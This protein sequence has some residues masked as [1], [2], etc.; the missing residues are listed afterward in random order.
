MARTW[1][2]VIIS[3]SLTISLVLFS[4]LLSVPLAH[5]CP[6]PRH[7]RSR[8]AAAALSEIGWQEGVNPLHYAQ[9]FLRSSV[10][11]IEK[12]PGR[13]VTFIPIPRLTASCG[14]AATS[15]SNCS[16]SRIHSPDLCVG[17]NL[18]DQREKSLSRSES[19]SGPKKRN[20]NRC[21]ENR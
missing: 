19:G 6:P 3:L 7:S 2:V 5:R 20:E 13:F 18:P 4:H 10:H 16:L 15:S 12:F 11:L 1:L 21:C 14:Y 9:S 17:E 8:V